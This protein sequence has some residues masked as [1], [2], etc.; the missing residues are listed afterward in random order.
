VSKVVV[1]LCILRR[2]AARRSIW[3]EASETSDL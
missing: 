1:I 2:L 3:A